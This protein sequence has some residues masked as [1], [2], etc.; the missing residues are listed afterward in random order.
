MK[1]PTV[2]AAA[3][4]ND[5]LTPVDDGYAV[6]LSE[7]PEDMARGLLRASLDVCEIARSIAIAEGLDWETLTEELR[8]HPRMVA[9]AIIKDITR[10]DAS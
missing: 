5:T 7:S 8:E 2:R 4:L 1:T 10:K 6:R 9:R 3:Y